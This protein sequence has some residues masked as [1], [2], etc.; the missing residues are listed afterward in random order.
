MCTV[1]FLS[2]IKNTQE[3][4]QLY[5]HPNEEAAYRMETKIFITYTSDR[6]LVSRI[7]KELKNLTPRKKLK[8]EAWHET[9]DGYS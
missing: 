4:C 3:N 7:Y 2:L 8:I 6:E 9:C 1:F 5:H